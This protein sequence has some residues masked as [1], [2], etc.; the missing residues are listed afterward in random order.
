MLFIEGILYLRKEIN[1]NLTDFNVVTAIL[2][3]IFLIPVL[4]GALE[5]FSR[6]R[7]QRSFASLLDNIEFLAGLVLAVY[8]T[9]KIFFEHND[10]IY[11]QIYAW[12]PESIKAMLYGRDVIVYITAMPVI[13][14]VVLGVLRLLTMP[15]YNYVLVPLSNGIY[16][17]ASSMNSVARRIIGALW[18]VPKS[19]FLVLIFGLLL[20]F[21]S[22][23]FSTPSLSRWMNESGA[24]QLLYKNAIYPI[25]NSNIAKKIPVLVN[26][27]FRRTSDRVVPE[28]EGGTGPSVSEQLKKQLAKGNIKVIEYFNGVTLD[29]AIKSSPEIDAAAKKIVGSEKND[30]KK[31]HLIY[32]WITR[33]ISYDYDKAVKVSRDPRGTSSGSVVAYETRKG[34]CFDYS[35]LYVSMCRAVGLKVRLVTG[36]G[37]SGVAWGDHAWNQV[38]SPDEKRWINVDSTFG[39][40]AN[41]FDKRDFNVDHKYA[42]IQGEW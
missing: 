21:Y 30:Y 7:V 36:L 19:A 22:Y 38:Y 14:L 37:Y 41:Y 17:A 10:G 27:S 11:A 29:E 4:I 34:I 16:F 35:C 8:L 18:Q 12:I 13:L 25:L 5:T 24:Y 32:R 1:L 39:T 31:A 6:E 15:F 33:N 42:D 3:V 23:Y 9:K 20:N 40:N 26:D 28:N 2:A